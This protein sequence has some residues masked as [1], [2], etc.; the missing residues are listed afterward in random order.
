LTGRPV[1]LDPPEWRPVEP[2]L[3]LGGRVRA[4]RIR[5]QAG[6]AS[7]GA[8]RV[9][10]RDLGPLPLAVRQQAAGVGARWGTG[11]KGRTAT[12]ARGVVCVGHWVGLR[13]WNS[14]RSHLF[15]TPYT[16]NFSKS[17]RKSE[18]GSADS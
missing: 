14:R 10:P 8:A 11:W 7:V 6:F 15:S 1:A 16:S 13:R 9:D 2:A 18:D 5:N 4:E 12:R 3:E 17:Y